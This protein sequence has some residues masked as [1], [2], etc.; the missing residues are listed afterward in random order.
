MT[1]PRVGFLGCGEIARLHAGCLAEIGVGVRGG[2][3][4]DTKT[5]ASFVK[6][7][8]GE[9]FSD[10]EELCRHPDIDAVY[11]CSRHDSHVHYIEL[12]SREKKAVYCEKPL[13]MT[14]QGALRARKVADRAGIPVVVGFNH[15]YSPG[16][17]AL[18]REIDARNGEIDAMI[19]QFATVPFLNGWAG[20]VDE[21]GGVFLALGSHVL[22]LAG[23]LCEDTITEVKA[24]SALKRYTPG[25]LPD[26]CGVLMRTQGGALITAGA[27]DFGMPIYSTSPGNNVN[28]THVFVKNAVITGKTTEVV[29]FEN[30]E[31]T[32]QDFAGTI[33]EIWGYR[34]INRRFISVV[35]GRDASVPGID[36]GL[37]VAELVER[38][39]MNAD[40]NGTR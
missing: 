4:I 28:V 20:S 34:E 40:L 6:D 30:G 35:L 13:A 26:T 38:C 25:G 23:Y 22:D 15:R 24:M 32:R 31:T 16:M 1:L 3:D 2:Y 8:G 9:S 5:A 7:F 21:G 19:I 39:R 27:H 18:K 14:V 29:V 10:A 11:I 17:R 37:R 12:A 33:E 36:S